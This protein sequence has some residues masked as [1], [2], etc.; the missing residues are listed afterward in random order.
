MTEDLVEILE[1]IVLAINNDYSF[2]EVELFINFE[3]KANKTVIAAAY[4]WIYEKL[5]REY[6]QKKTL[7]ENTSKSVRIFSEEEISSIGLHNYNYILHFYNIGLINNNDMDMI[8][9]QIKL[10]PEESRSIENL[11]I[12]ILSVFLDLDDI[13]TPGSRYLLYSSDTIN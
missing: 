7:K 8:L 5:L 4:S 10:F 2:E 3:D 11:N 6:Y 1:K 13:S 9:D 12:L